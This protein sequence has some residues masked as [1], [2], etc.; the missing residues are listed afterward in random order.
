MSDIEQQLKPQFGL[1]LSNRGLVTG[2]TTVE[3]LLTLAQK[4]EET[5][6]DSIWVGDSILAKPL[7][8]ALVLLSALAVRTHR[9]RLGP[10][11]FTSTPLRNSLQLAYQWYS[12]DVLSQ[13][14]MIFNASQG[15]PGPQGGTFAEEFAAFHIDPTSRMRRMEEAIEILRLTSTQEL[16]SYD[17]E[18]NHFHNVAIL[19]RPIQQP[20]PIWI[21]TATDPRK[22]KMTERALRRVAKYADGWMTINR[23]PALFA[24]NLR[25]I[26]RYARE[27]GRNLGEHFEAT[28]YLDMNVND[29]DQVAFRKS[30][31]F[32][33]AYYEHDFSRAEVEMRTVFGPP[34]ACI[35]RLQQ[36]IQAGVTTFTLRPIGDDD[37]QQF[38]RITHEVLAAFK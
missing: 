9:V 34:Q 25:D 3:E 11:S 23:P 7:L 26:H 35:A 17:G 30:K 29:D 2:S 18:Y 21:S 13:G 1:V 22:P 14:R 4:A 36:F 6:W 37:A 28:L 15:A 24:E 31:Q 5:G 10:A 33:D 12:L 16:V 19:P 38:E 27:M 8:D 20:L 32:L